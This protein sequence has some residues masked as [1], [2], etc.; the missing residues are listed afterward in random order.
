LL[1]Y[2]WYE[3]SRWTSRHHCQI[4]INKIINEYMF[5][6]LVLNQETKLIV[7]LNKIIEV[8]IGQGLK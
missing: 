3:L 1:W 8:M 4:I 2:P 7:I 5:I 6:F